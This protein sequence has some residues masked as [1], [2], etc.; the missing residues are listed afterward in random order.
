MNRISDVKYVDILSATKDFKSDK[1]LK[2]SILRNITVEPVFDTYLFYFLSHIGYQADIKYGEYD[3]V[4]TEVMEQKS[5]L[6]NCSVDYVILALQLQKLSE[7]LY[8]D[9]L[10]LSE[11]EIKGEQ[12][13]IFL[14]VKKVIENIKKKTSADIILWGFES[15]NFSVVGTNNSPVDYIRELNAQIKK[16]LC[17]DSSV[18]YVDLDCSIMRVGFENYYDYRYMYIGHAPYK[19]TAIKDIS[20]ECFRYMRTKLGKNKKCIVVDCDN[21]LWGGICGE[22]ELQHLKLSDSF[23]GNMYVEFQKQ[24]K[25]LNEMGVLIALCSKNEEAD[26][27]NVFENHPDMVLKKENVAAYRINWNNKNNNIGEIAK[28]LNISTDSMVFV[29]DNE[30][31]TEIV[32]QYLPEVEV[33]LFDTKKV[34]QNIINIQQSGLFSNFKMTKED[35]IR[36]KTYTQEKERKKLLDNCDDLQGYYQS[37]Q[38][39]PEIFLCDKFYIPRVSQLTQRTNQ[40]N[41]STKRYS[42]NQIQLFCES[43]DYE[44]V[45]IKLS[46]RFG[47][48]GLIGCGVLDFSGEEAVLD[49]FLLSCRALGRHVQDLLLET[50]VHIAKDK[51][52]KIKI[53]YIPTLRNKQVKDFFD[54]IE[55]FKIEEFKDGTVHYNASLD[56]FVYHVEDVFQEIRSKL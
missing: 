18:Q 40:F 52:K 39:I 15:N 45:C 28:E 42:E 36:V 5:D 31:E 51:K 3:N 41:L 50:L 24:L 33:F 4:M 35:R 9:W 29:D 6:L 14:Y 43:E 19:E 13:R 27:W 11:E 38:M 46:D 26:V 34:Y 30:M 48:Y 20:F 53:P 23:P 47:E 22:D 12:E 8:Y 10:S 16:E 55:G 49:T 21:V 56:E 1:K 7:K 17:S 32:R 2:I 25:C 54:A 44:V 37:L